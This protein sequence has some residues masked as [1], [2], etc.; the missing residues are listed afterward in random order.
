[1]VLASASVKELAIINRNGQTLCTDRGD[2]FVVRDVV[3]T[4]P[5][6]DSEI[7]LDI[8]RT[9]ESNERLLRV[10]RLAS[11]GKASFSA[12]VPVDQLLPRVAPNGQIGTVIGTAGKN[13][14]E[15][16]QTDPIVARAVSKR[17][18]PVATI[19]TIRH[20]AIANHDDLRRIS[21]VFTAIAAI[22]I[23]LFAIL[24]RRW[25]SNDRLTVVQSALISD[26]LV[27]YYQPIVDINSGKLLG[28]EN[29]KCMLPLTSLPNTSVTR[30]LSM[31]SVPS[32][33]RRKS[34]SRKSDKCQRASCSENLHDRPPQ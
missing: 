16:K 18:G 15:S 23:L 14:S 33:R 22:V 17:Y 30:P 29:H 24:V 19:K 11:K 8:V 13:L 31:T 21:I 10:R 1:M 27:P 26:E 12:L 34:G 4:A 25:Q 20:G 7:T 28:A 9:T 3:A 2:A 5:T 32:S 6:S